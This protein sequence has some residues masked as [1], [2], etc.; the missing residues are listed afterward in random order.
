MSPE[1]DLFE[2]CLR[3]AEG[4]FLSM[5]DPCIGVLVLTYMR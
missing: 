5:G 4:V 1:K 3:W 2:T